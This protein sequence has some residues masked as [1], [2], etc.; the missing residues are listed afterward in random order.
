MRSPLPSL[1]RRSSDCDSPPRELSGLPGSDFFFGIRV[2]T[3][4]FERIQGMPSEPA[5]LQPSDAELLGRLRSGDAAAFSLA[6]QRHQRRIYVFLLRLCRQPEQAEDLWQETFVR[7]GRHAADLDPATPL[8]PWLYTVA[9]NLYRSECRKSLGWRRILP[10]LDQEFDQPAP[11]PYTLAIAADAE[12]QLESALLAL[13]DAYREPL[14]LVAVEQLDP[15]QVATVL[16]LS[17]A[18]LRQ[19]LSR[20]RAMLRASLGP[21]PTEEIP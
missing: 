20:G 6:W 5:H 14:L 19:R 18:A 2:T 15:S 9:R 16:N 4:P 17:P 12:R 13:P 7:L 21:A 1:T 3:A 10:L 11:T 8:L